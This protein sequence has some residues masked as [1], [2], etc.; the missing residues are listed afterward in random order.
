MRVLREQNVF[1]TGNTVLQETALRLHYFL[2]QAHPAYAKHCCLTGLLPVPPLAPEIQPGLVCAHWGQDMTPGVSFTD[3]T[4]S[5]RSH[6]TL[7]FTLG[8]TK[9]DMSE[10]A[11]SAD[12]ADAAFQQMERF[13]TTPL[14]SKRAGLPAA[15]I[16]EVRAAISQ[17][18]VDM[19]DKQSLVIEKAAFPARLRSILRRLQLIFRKPKP[20]RV[21]EEGGGSSA[22][23]EVRDMFGDAIHL[24]PTLE[25]VR[26]LEDLLTISKAV[27]AAENSLCYFL[28][29]L[30]D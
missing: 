15:S 13:V 29:D 6:V 19:E 20:S 9:I 21:G 11:T 24:P 5:Q 22:D 28:R 4:R 1:P 18:R 30:L 23:D 17:L 2:A 25:V 8:T 10:S 16:R 12:D 3:D 14:L 7:F 27:S 26:T